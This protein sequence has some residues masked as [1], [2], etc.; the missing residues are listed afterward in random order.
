M[1]IKKSTFVSSSCITER[2]YAHDSHFIFQNKNII[3]KSNKSLLV[4]LS[5]SVIPGFRV[6]KL[7]PR[8][9]RYNLIKDSMHYHKEGDIF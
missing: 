3:I 9:L 1:I 7:I 6:K 8:A 2:L 4:K 5:S